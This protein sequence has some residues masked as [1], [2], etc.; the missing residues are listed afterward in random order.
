MRR[1]LM[2]FV[3]VLALGAVSAPAA[4]AINSDFPRGDNLPWI[5]DTDA[6]DWSTVQINSPDG[7][8][9]DEYV[10]SCDF[11]TDSADW[12]WQYG[13]P[14]DRSSQA[15]VDEHLSGYLDSDGTVVVED[16][17]WWNGPYFG[18]CWT[19]D[20]GPAPLD[21]QICSH[22]VTG[23]TWVRQELALA[24]TSYGT[25]QTGASFGR[26]PATELSSI[27]FGSFAYP[28][29]PVYVDTEMGGSLDFKHSVQFTIQGW[30]DSDPVEAYEIVVPESQEENPCGWPELS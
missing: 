8:C 5:P 6:E 2:L 13:V 1:F 30:Q 9:G 17:G 11:D 3:A 25:P 24:P 27:E 22:V 12:R 20:V 23:E 16:A 19:W 29:P 26:V 18:F 15:C 4:S 21:G 10:P 7:A 14:N 28:S